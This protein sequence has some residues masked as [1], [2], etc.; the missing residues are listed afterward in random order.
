VLP[1]CD[2]EQAERMVERLQPLMPEKQTFSAGIATWNGLDGL[3]ELL[4]AADRALLQA[5]RGG[6]N[7]IV[8]SGREPQISLPLKLVS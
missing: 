7:R 6:R 5:K 4:A 2:E 3:A 8:I 1:A